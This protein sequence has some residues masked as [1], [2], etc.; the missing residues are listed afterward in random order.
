MAT[1]TVS[2]NATATPAVTL[3][4]P[5]SLDELQLLGSPTINIPGTAAITGLMG[6][7]EGTYVIVEP[8]G[9]AADNGTAL[10]AAVV[11]AKN[12]SGITETN[13]SV[14][15]V[16]P[17]QYTLASTLEIDSQFLD[18]VGL[19]GDSKS[20]YI[21]GTIQQDVP[22]CNLSGLWIKTLS[23]PSGS[24]ADS[25]CVIDNCQ[26]GD[27]GTGGFLEEETL[28]QVFRNCLVYYNGY[29]SVGVASE[30]SGIVEYSKIT[31]L[32][33]AVRL[34]VVSAGSIIRHSIVDGE[35]WNAS[36]IT[37]SVYHCSLSLAIDSKITNNI[38][39][40]YNVVDANI[41]V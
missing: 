21:D 26:I 31:H 5:V 34:V 22:N 35:L 23:C 33:S 10:A 25:T 20:V 32:G 11:E 39:T 37:A 6:L 13:R 28:P 41:T 2:I 40:S 1:T 18:I 12:M 16:P 24:T 27:D 17:G 29:S 38:G 30:F 19:S 15:L 7:Q 4:N 36:A 9:V 14:V 8:T 3:S